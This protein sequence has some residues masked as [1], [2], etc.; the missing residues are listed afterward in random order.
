MSRLLQTAMDTTR[1]AQQVRPGEIR[2]EE[3]PP[4]PLRRGGGAGLHRREV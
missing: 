1:L 4:G 2:L 3:L